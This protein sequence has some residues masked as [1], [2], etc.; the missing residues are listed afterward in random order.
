MKK[1]LLLSTITLSA[2]LLHAE[3]QPN[4]VVF[5]VDDMGWQDTSVPFSDTITPL[6]EIYQTPNMVRLAE[7]GDRKS[8]V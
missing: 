3:E 6:N 1:T 5:L 4:I 8:V 7:K 2:T